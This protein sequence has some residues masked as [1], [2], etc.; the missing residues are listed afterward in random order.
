MRKER[1]VGKKERQLKT[2]GYINGSI[3]SVFWHIW[4]AIR[5]SKL[6]QKVGR[7][8]EEWNGVKITE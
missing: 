8:P 3:N 5:T 6:E 7:L 4:K 2:P 1:E